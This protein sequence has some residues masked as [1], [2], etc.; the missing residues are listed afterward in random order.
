VDTTIDRQTNEV[1]ARMEIE[2]TDLLSRVE[3]SEQMA[4]VRQAA[5]FNRLMARGGSIIAP[6]VTIGAAVLVIA[7]L[8]FAVVALAGQ[9]A[10]FPTLVALCVY[11]AVVD[12]LA[13]ATRLTAML[14]YR[15][16]EVDTSLGLLVPASAPP[17]ALRLVLSGLDPFRA[18][19]WVLIAVGLVVTGQLTRRAALGT[20]AAF[21]LLS[22]GIRMIPTPGAAPG[23]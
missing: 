5:E 9:K 13:A 20:A 16:V 10:D 18:W 19:F 2:Q 22:A 17:S 14:I 1:L 8:L 4:K 3:L 15:T 6:P 12:V 11:A 21:F 7:A 23:T